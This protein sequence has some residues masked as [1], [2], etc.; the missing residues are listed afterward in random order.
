MY[1]IVVQSTPENGLA[2]TREQ[3][4]RMPLISEIWDDESD[5]PEDALKDAE[6]VICFSAEIY[7]NAGISRCIEIWVRSDEIASIPN[8]KVD[9]EDL[10]V[11]VDGQPYNPYD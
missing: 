7:S 1:K 6:T 2:I 4:I 8:H 5:T 3:V 9:N 11:L 10:T